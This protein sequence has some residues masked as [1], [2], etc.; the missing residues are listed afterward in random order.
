MFKKVFFLALLLV[1]F[2]KG[3][4]F[5]LAQEVLTW[6]DCLKEAKRNN[7]DYLSAAEN[8]E[9]SKADKK[10]AISNL[11]PQI[12]AEAGGRTSKSGSASAS[13]TYS[14]GLSANQ[15]IFDS[16]KTT[17]N[18]NAAKYN[19]TAEEYNY[20]VTSSNIRLNLK[21]AYVGLLR[22]QELIS[23]TEDIAAR[24][25][26]NLEMIQ[27]RYKAGREHKGALLTAQADLAQADFEVLQAKRN[28]SLAQRQL[29]LELGRKEVSPVEIKGDFLIKEDNRNKPD[30]EYLAEVTPLLNELI[31]KK[32]AARYNLASSKAELFPD[33]YLS[34]SLGRSQ[35]SWPPEEDN[36]S[37]GLSVSIPIFEGGSNYTQIQKSKSQLR[38]AE[39][40][41]RSGWDQVV[42]TLE[43]T[44]KDLQD[45]IDNVY[46]Q[47][48]F[49]GAAQ[50]RAK[51]AEAQYS[52]GI[53]DFDDWIIIE[54]NLVSAK[55]TY[56]NV[57]A[58]LLI[59]E[60]NWVQA[61][62]GTLNYD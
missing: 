40:E 17:S 18:I 15:L 62:G 51:I 30:F 5:C 50:E 41:E 8:V 60:A 59:A 37:A 39:L 32:E 21:S 55:K 36:W 35:D 2:L 49:L 10:L 24:R 33:V 47:K 12:T 54:D 48:M 44:W 58:N 45:A 3:T 16:F 52:N 9:Q 31:A 43:E 42:L 14:Y 23:L 46:V 53:I 13:D 26:Q 4:S 25:K 57:Q 6:E 22:A 7:P 28:L 11:L 27:L 61:K 29:L 1:I 56:L 38:Q 19:L 34:G 20:A